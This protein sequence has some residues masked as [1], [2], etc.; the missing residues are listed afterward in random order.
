MIVGEQFAAQER[1]QVSTDILVFW[2]ASM[3]AVG[4]TEETDTVY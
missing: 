2:D 4:L 1:T 3:P